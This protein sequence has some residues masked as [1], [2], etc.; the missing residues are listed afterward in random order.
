MSSALRVL[1]RRSRVDL[2][3]AADAVRALLLALG[4]DPDSES[5][6]DTPA[7]VAAAY[8]ELIAPREFD[9]TTFPND[10]GYDEQAYCDAYRV[11]DE[12]VN[13]INLMQLDSAAY[14]D[15]TQQVE[16]VRNLAPLEMRDEWDTLIRALDE[17]EQILEDAGLSL[18]DLQ[19]FA[20]GELPEGVDF[21]RLQELGTRMQEFAEQAEF[22]AAGD[23]IDQDAETRCN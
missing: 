11:A 18:D 7:R 9:L 12:T 2:D 19:G 23:R 20:R 14:D 17:F 6:A 10:E 16:Q 22:Q 8:A 4:R 3:A 5:L 21:S 1:H 13:S 15:F